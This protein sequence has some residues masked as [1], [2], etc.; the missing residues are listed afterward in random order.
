MLKDID[1][2]IFDDSGLLSIVDCSSYDSFLSE[3][4]DYESI[5]EHFKIQMGLRSILVWECGDGGGPYLIR[6]RNYLSQEVGFREASGSI[7][8]KSK[9]LHFV[10]YDALTMAAQFEDEVLPSKHEVE[11]AISVSPG[12]FVIRIVQ[13]FDPTKL[14][15]LREGMPHF[16][17]EI[18]PGIS[19]PWNEVAWV[20]S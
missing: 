2:T 1:L 14:D 12:V 18:I 6:V 10:S 8:A 11:L 17:V 9:E 5:Q 19:Q 13:M 16:L 3:N 15:A 7:E 20:S 4:W